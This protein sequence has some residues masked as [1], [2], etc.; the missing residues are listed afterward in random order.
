MYKVLDLF[1]GAGGLSFGFEESK[2]FYIILANDIMPDAISTYQKNYPN[3]NT[4][5]CDINELSKSILQQYYSDSVDLI[6]GGPPCQSFSTLGKRLLDDPRGKLF[7]EYLRLIKLIRPK[8]FIFE[9]VTGLLSMDK[10]KLFNIIISSFRKEGYNVTYKVL[11]FA[12]FG[13]PQ[14]RKRVIII[15][16]IS[17]FSEFNFPRMTHLNNHLYL[18]DAISDLPYLNRHNYN[19]YICEPQNYFQRYARTG[20]NEL[21]YHDIPNHG[22][23]LLKIIRAIPE[24][25]SA[26]K[27]IPDEIKPKSGFKN[28]YARM[29]WD[30]PSGTITGNFGTPSSTRCIHPV[31]DR[32]LTTREG[33][34]IQ[35]FPDR[36][37]FHGSRTSKNL[38]IGNAVPPIFS[39]RLVVS[40]INYL[41][42]KVNI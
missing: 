8:I 16:Y 25:G 11:N 42:K 21:K 30:K 37:I 36:Y 10:G 14:N 26:M 18:F 4:L 17:E 29:W 22:E 28:S 27:D 2:E 33:A 3:T 39:R 38:Q 24:G 15:G 1:C 34:R 20:N 41:K 5:C 35:S 13:I 40:V 23:S 12:D 31:A 32:A 19:E 6:L 7:Q 9:N